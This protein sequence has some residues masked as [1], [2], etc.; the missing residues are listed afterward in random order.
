[1][2]DARLHVR[3]MVTDTGPL[4]T[5]AAA[6][7]L[8]YLLYPDMPVYV[9]DAVVYEATI[10]SDA[11]GAQAIADWLGR[12]VEVVHVVVT[13]AFTDHLAAV[14]AGARQRTP[15]LGERAAIE[16][17]RNSLLLGADDRALL[18][19]EDDYV[20]RG[21]YIVSVEDR[22]RTILAT[23]REFL[24]GLERAGLIN[25]AEEVYRRAENAG[26]FASRKRILASQHQS[27]LDAVERALGVRRE[28]S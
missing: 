2:S 28:K 23:T 19:T 1:M 16:A 8:D 9:P 10:T 14:N 20:I 18:L 15:D 6:D 3:L 24:D 11:L 5:L 27:A 7:S 21:N 4:I 13:Q 22:G 25:S 12:H 26:R 17:I